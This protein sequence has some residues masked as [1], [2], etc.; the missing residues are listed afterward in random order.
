MKRAIFEILMALG[1][2]ACKIAWAETYVSGTITGD[3]T[4]NLAGSPYIATDTVYV[5]NGIK[6]TINPGVTVKFATETSLI[7]YG[8]LNAIGTPLGTITFTS[9]QE[10][11]TVG[12]W[13]GIKLSGS[14][15][16]GSRISY[17]DIGYAK[18][19][20][21]LENAS[22]ITIT[23]NYIHDNKGN[24]GI[25]GGQGQQGYIGC[26]IYLSSSDNNLIK[27]NTIFD[28]T[29]GN[30]GYSTSWLSSGGIGGTGA[31]IYLSL[32]QN[33][34][35]IKNLI[36]DNTGGQGGSGAWDGTGGKGGDG[37]G[38]FLSFSFT[39]IIRE[40]VIFNNSGGKGGSG[41]GNGTGGSGGSG[42]GI[43]LSFS[44]GNTIT[45]NKISCN[46]GGKGY[47]N[48][49]GTCYAHG[50]QGGD[51]VGIYIRQCSNNNIENNMISENRGGPGGTGD[52]YCGMGNSGGAG[53]LG[54]GIYLLS[55]TDTTMLK[56]T[57]SHNT[58]GR[59][60]T[61]SSPWVG[62]G[63]GGIGCGIYLY[64]S[65]NRIIQNII[66]NNQGGAGGPGG[67]PGL[68][69]KGYG[70][71]SVSNSFCE[72]H[73]NNLFGNKNGDLT[74]G[75]GVYHD[76]SSGTI[77]ATYNWW[78]ANSGPEHPITNPSG[79]GDKVSDWVDYWPWTAITLVNPNSGPIG[80]IVTIEGQGFTTQTQVF[81][82]F[83]THPTIAARES[84][85]TGTFSITFM[86]DT[87]PVCTK[88]ITARN[89]YGKSATTLF[90]LM[91]G[92]LGISLRKECPSFA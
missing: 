34:T 84:S 29:G 79:Q 13:K 55:S 83:G 7:C 80:T 53:G 69:N 38:I 32:S 65:T 60:G 92:V 46:S 36:F 21:Y 72:I 57:I 89:E 77:S 75:Y 8:T 22:G 49:T 81:I 20:I 9:D 27:A 71:C 68:S 11:H 16:S 90:K 17:C 54:C 41:G 66:S 10:T 47:G 85:I 61:T 43:F 45:D 18:Q 5:V 24:D 76:G 30:G 39:N 56:N 1:F 37:S 64:S 58:G 40:N 82:D 31:G 59:G 63:P 3:T 25:P 14:G 67:S 70:I 50:G 42:V 52:E 2:M 44:S 87:Q 48:H 88:V 6:L 26:G 33:N 12:H 15:A 91:S 86:V 74:K 51:G 62:G 4:W 35:I 73:C 28:N 23:N 78:G 19:A